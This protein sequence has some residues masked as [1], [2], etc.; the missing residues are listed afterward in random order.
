MEQ[1][2][3]EKLRQ[4]GVDVS[5]DTQHRTDAFNKTHPL[6]QIAENGANAYQRVPG[7]DSR[8]YVDKDGFKERYNSKVER[9]PNGKSIITYKLFDKI[10]N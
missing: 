4:Q 9:N 8:G 5:S 1:Y 3:K 10:K 7:Y 2:E 6:A